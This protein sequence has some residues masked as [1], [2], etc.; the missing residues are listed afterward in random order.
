[1]RTA[2]VVEMPMG[3]NLRSQ[4]PVALTIRQGR[5]KSAWRLHPSRLTWAAGQGGQL[6]AR[7]EP[8]ITNSCPQAEPRWQ[9]RVRA[10]GSRQLDE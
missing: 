1:M 7:V 2:S 5:N 9:G 8:T 3:P 10:S 6:V 4:W